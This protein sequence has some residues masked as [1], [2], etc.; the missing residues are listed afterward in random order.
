VTRSGLASVT[1]G[2]RGRAFDR[3]DAVHVAIVDVEGV[4]VADEQ[5]PL[6]RVAELA[7][8]DEVREELGCA[9][10]LARTRRPSVSF[11]STPFSERR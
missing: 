8:L 11:V 5:D 7:R 3:R 6:V 9:L 10:R 1:A 2:C 4:E